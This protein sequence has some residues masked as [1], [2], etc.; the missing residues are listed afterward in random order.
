VTQDTKS[1]WAATIAN[2]ANSTSMTVDVT[3]QNTQQF[4]LN[5]GNRVWYSTSQSSSGI[6]IADAYGKVT[7][8]ATTIVGSTVLTFT[9]LGIFP[10]PSGVTR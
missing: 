7:L 8:P 3:P 4:K 2:S 9:K 6:L 1:H 5:P 10:M